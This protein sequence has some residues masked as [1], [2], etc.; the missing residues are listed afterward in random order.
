MAG[1]S[2]CDKYLDVMPDNRAELN[3]ETKI[4]KLLVSAYPEQAYLSSAEFSSDNVDDYGASNP[5]NERLIE[6]LFRWTDVTEVGTDSPKDLWEACY[7]AI[8]SANQALAAI[9]EMGNPS[10]LN[11][12]R[13]EALAARAYNHFILVNVF[14]QHYTKEHAATDLGITYM[15]APETELNPKYERNTVAEVYSYI[16]EDLATAIPLIDDSSYGATPKFHMNHA[17][18]NALAARVAL[19]MQKW[20]DAVR[21]ATA[22]VGTNP[23]SMLRDNVKLSANAVNGVTDLAVF[24]NSSAEAANLFL[25]TAYSNQGLFFGA[26]YVGSRFSHG[27]YIASTETIL[28]DAPWGSRSSTGYIPRAFVYSGTNLDKVLMARVS[29]MFEYTDPVAGIGYRRGVYAPFTTEE[30]MLVR[31][32]AL[33]H[34]KRYNEAVVDMKRWVNNTLT[35]PPANFTVESINNWAESLAYFTPK[36]PTPKKKFNAEFPIEVGTQENMLHALLFIRRIETLHLGLRW[37]DVKRYGI[38]IERRVMASG[39]VSSVESAT[40]LTPRDNRQALQI[41]QDVI[42]AGLTP[43]PR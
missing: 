32:E 8:S 30:T 11:A 2:S 39:Q 6:Q 7:S 33:I 35:A 16:G 20:E 19:Y 40:K 29:Y 37:F 17:A 34:L 15:L 21:Y 26:Y 24:Y 3:N 23:S 10:T 5:N 28:S 43:N 41:P 36:M 1:L 18:A 38:E 14:A 31:A 4:D 42:S 27:N 22:A 25:Q 9:E 12:Q 13:G